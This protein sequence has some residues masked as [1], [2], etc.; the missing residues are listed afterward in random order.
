MYNAIRSLLTFI[1]EIFGYNQFE[2]NQILSDIGDIIWT[3]IIIILIYLVL[4]FLWFSYK[5]WYRDNK[6]K[7]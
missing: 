3:I 7:M 1:L 4:S 2:I 6:H 5:E